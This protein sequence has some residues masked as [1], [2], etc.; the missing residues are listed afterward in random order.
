MRAIMIETMPAGNSFSTG[1][2]TP[3][4]GEGWNRG[5]SPPS[6]PAP[7]EHRPGSGQ[8]WETVSA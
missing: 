2:P 4:R 3:G 8:L 6:S 7:A 1:P 5:I